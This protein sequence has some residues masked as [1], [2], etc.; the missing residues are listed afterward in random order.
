MVYS[1]CMTDGSAQ[2]NN[3]CPRLHDSMPLVGSN[4]YDHAVNRQGSQRC[5]SRGCVFSAETV[6]VPVS[7]SITQ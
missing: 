6:E 1:L 5:Q 7:V 4:E 2:C 3:P